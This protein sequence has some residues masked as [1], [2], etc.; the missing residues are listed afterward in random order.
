MHFESY[1]YIY[2]IE[3]D[4]NLALALQ[5]VLN[6]QGSENGRYYMPKVF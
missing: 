3:D 4:L 6:H 1:A 5:L 2:G